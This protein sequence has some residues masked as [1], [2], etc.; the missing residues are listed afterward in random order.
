M[1]KERRKGLEALPINLVEKLFK[2]HIYDFESMGISEAYC[3]DPTWASIEEGEEV[4]TLLSS[5]IVE[6]IED[7]FLIHRDYGRP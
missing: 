3:G 7:T 2:E 4:L 5:F 1:N 6:D